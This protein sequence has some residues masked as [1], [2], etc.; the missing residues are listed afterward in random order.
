MSDR[1]VSLVID[2]LDKWLA[3]LEALE[4]GEVDRMK[5]R[6]LRTMGLRV[7]EYADDLTPRRTGRLQ[8][9]IS[10][11][12]RDNVFN[13]QIGAATS[14]IVVGTAV[15]YAEAVEKGFTQRRGQFVPGFWSSGTFHYDPGSRTGMVLTGKVIEGAHMFRKAMDYVEN[16]VDAIALFEF[17]R[18][19][20]ALF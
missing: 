4:T 14:F 1:E 15:E 3:W 19:Y 13:L 16:D 9:S 10:M 7:L 2:N 18:L 12:D 5:S 20:D 6:I 8:N 17:R 11:G